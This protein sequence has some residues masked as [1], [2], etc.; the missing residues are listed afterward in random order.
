MPKGVLEELKKKTPKNEA[1]KPTAKFHQS[2]TIDIGEPN[3][4]RQITKVIAL[5]QI[6]DNMEQFWNNFQKMKDRQN[7]QLELPFEFD[8]EGHTKE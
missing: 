7:G 6:S 4:E 8:K 3:L 5:C 1:G 2:L